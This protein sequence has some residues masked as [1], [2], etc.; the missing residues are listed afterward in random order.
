MRIPSWFE[1]PGG[2]E[3]VTEDHENRLTNELAKELPQGHVLFGSRVTARGRRTD[4][5]DVLFITDIEGKPFL[6]VH[7]T[8]RSLAQSDPL[9]PHTQSFASLEAWIEVEEQRDSQRQ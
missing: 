3:P 5:D 1:L 8:W 2:W 7:M 6:I 4:S 9:W